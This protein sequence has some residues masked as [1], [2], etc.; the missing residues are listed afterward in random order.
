[1]PK[2]EFNIGKSGAA[3]L[4]Q[5]IISDSEHS[6]ALPESVQLSI[7][8]DKLI[9]LRKLATERKMV[10]YVGILLNTEQPRVSVF[11]KAEAKRFAI[12]YKELEKF[13]NDIDKYLE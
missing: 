13:I 4:L 2:I 8:R 6:N 3:H 12:A 1:M 5:S 9:E 7:E 11:E 10:V